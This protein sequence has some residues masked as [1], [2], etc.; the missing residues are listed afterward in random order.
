MGLTSFALVAF[1]AKEK[2]V[3][4]AAWIY[5][6][7][8]Q[9][10]ACA[11]ML[12][13]VLL[14]RP[15]CQLAA[16]TCAIVGFGLKI[17]FPPFHSW[18][19]EA[20]PAAPAPASAIMSGAMIPLGFCGMMK[21][22]PVAAMEPWQAQIYG[23]TFLALGAAGAA[24]G[25]LFALP[26]ANLKRLLAFSSVENM[27]VVAMGLGLGALAAGRCAPGH[28]TAVCTAG[29]LVHILNHAFL[30]GALFLAAGSVFRQTG[31]LDQ[32]RLG[33]I[34]RRMPITGT[35]F[36]VNAFGLSGLP[37][38][39]GFLG[40]LAIYIGA[41]SAV[42][43]GDPVLVS[44]GFL[45]SVSLALTG[46][47]AVAAY[48]K[49]IGGVFLGEPRSKSAAEAVETPRRMWI[50]QLFL[51]VLS[52]AMIPVSVIFVDR[53]TGGF[54]TGLMFTAAVSGLVFAAVAA[55]LLLLRRFAC[56]RGAEKPR[57]PVWD[58]GYENPTPRMAYTATAFTQPLADLF[59]P[60]LRSSRHVVPFKGDPAS[61]SDAAIA[62]GTD[63]LALKG[64]WRP[65]FTRVAR[66]FQRVHLLQ[67]G[68]LHLYILI[69]LLAVTALLVSA[70]V[71]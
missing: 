29:A 19:P 18:L 70:L 3:R 28:L 20:H 4:K 1:D 17:G 54:A 44:A 30:K 51:T 38:L 11:L 21:F 5:L 59:R 34:L 8:C 14:S 47:L 24:G 57:L 40:E 41:F 31:T 33:R 43:S 64:L 23:W 45:V 36:T 32:D 7:A 60:L 69:I 63:D 53:M 62:D 26:Q 39:N 13:G 52:V 67:N 6:L 61:P 56:P 25:I 37:P 58:C 35:L 49:A 66:L 2:S 10:G 68:S 71:S 42:R 46:G 9:A 22:F 16:F 48:A 15:N 65:L 27:G 50:A 55:A 12:G